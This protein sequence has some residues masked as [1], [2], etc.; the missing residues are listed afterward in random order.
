MTAGRDRPAGILTEVTNP[1]AEVT[2]NPQLRLSPTTIMYSG[3]VRL[4]DTSGVAVSRA[5]K[6]PA[7]AAPAA[8]PGHAGRLAAKCTCHAHARVEA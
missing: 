7:G 5:G 3:T 8:S 1:V 6:P 2:A 4:G